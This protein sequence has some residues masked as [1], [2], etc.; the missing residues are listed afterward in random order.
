MAV[1]R[2]LVDLARRTITAVSGPSIM[3]KP[4]IPARVPLDTYPMDRST[5][6][7]PAV[8]K[9]MIVKF[10]LALKVGVGFLYHLKKMYPSVQLSVPA[11]KPLTTL[12]RALRL[13]VKNELPNRESVQ[14]MQIVPITL[15][16]RRVPVPASTEQFTIQRLIVMVTVPSLSASMMTIVTHY[17]LVPNVNHWRTALG[18][19]IASNQRMALNQMLSKMFWDYVGLVSYWLLQNTTNLMIFYNFL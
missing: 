9:T 16:A 11:K 10:T 13:L 2:L 7:K 17:G 18:V 3:L 8:P 5:V 12:N 4:T 14:K 19:V 6:R 1:K 15:F